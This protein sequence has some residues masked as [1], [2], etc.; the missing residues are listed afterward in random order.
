LALGESEQSE[1]VNS[2]GESVAWVF[3]GLSD[4]V[5][6][7]LDSIESGSEV[8][9]ALHENTDPQQLVAPKGRLTAILMEDKAQLRASDLLLDRFRRCLLESRLGGP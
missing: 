7:S 6:L 2:E 1:Y 9:S 3:R 4:L 8:W 5:E